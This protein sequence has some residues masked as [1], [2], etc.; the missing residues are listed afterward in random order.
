M[1]GLILTFETI[2]GYVTLGSFIEKTYPHFVAQ[3]IYFDG[4]SFLGC[5]IF[6][7]ESL[8]TVYIYFETFASWN[9][10]RVEFIFKNFF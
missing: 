4:I 7:T 10:N 5:Q 6:V 2:N 1:Q 8:K 9:I 3:R